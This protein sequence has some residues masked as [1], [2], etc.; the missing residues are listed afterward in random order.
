MKNNFLWLLFLILSPFSVS[1]QVLKQDTTFLTGRLKNGLTYYI[2][3]NDKEPGLA[4]FYIAK[5]VGS[6]LEE[7]RQRGL[8]H[9][10]EHMAFNGTTN[11][12]GDSKSPGIVSWCESVGVKFGANL[13]A[14]TSV[15]QTVYNIA[16]VPIKRQEVLDSALLILHD[17]CHGLLLTDKEIDKE[18]GVIH[19]EWRTRRAGKATQRMMERVLPMVYRGTK[20]EDCLPIGSMDIVDH[21][22]YHDLRDYYNKWY[23]PD[24]D[25]II[26]VGDIRPAEVEAKI[27]QLFGTIP[28]PEHAAERVYY[29][30]ADNDRIIVATDRDSEQPI[31]L[32]TLFMKHNA[33]SDGEKNTIGY[34]RNS[35]IESLIVSM[36]NSRL[37]ELQHQTVPPVLSATAHSGS[38]LVSKTKDAFWLSF[39][40]R[41]ENV[42]G[43][44][45]AVIAESE[46]ARRY[47]FMKSELQR[48]QERQMRMAESQYTERND[49][50]NRYFVN[51]A[52][53]NFLSNEPVVTEAYRREL[54]RNFS[55]TIS[56]EEVNKAVKSLI[57]DQNQVLVVYAPDKP[58]F[59]IPSNKVL[60]QYVLDAQA[61]AYKP[62]TEP[63]LSQKLLD[64]LPPSGRIV[65]EHTGLHG[66]K[67]LKLSNGVT[68]YVKQTRF[69]KDRVSMRF[70][71]EGGTSCYPD[72]DA[73][74]FPFIATAITDG[75][76]GKFDKSALRKMLASKIVHVAPSVSEDTQELSGKSSVRDLKTMLELTCLYFTEPRKDSIAFN[77]AMDRMYSFLTNREANPKV[78]Y[79]DS[80]VS[81]LYGNHLRMQPTRRETLK[82]VS[83][84]RVWQIY[85]ELFADASRFKML[86]VGNINIDSLRP[87]LCRYIASLPSGK[88]NTA[89]IT[90]TNS[91]KYP[92]PDVRNANELHLFKKKMNTPSALVNIFYTFEEPYTAKSDITLDVLQRVLQMAYTDSVREEKGGTYGVSV[93]YNLEKDKRPAAMLRITFRTDPAKYDAIIPVVYRQIKHIADYGPNPESM[94]KVKKY[95]LKN[96]G[97]NIIDN[98]YWDYVIYHQLQDG[99]DF[100]T[101]YKKMVENITGREVQQMAGNILNSHRRIEVT[102]L[103]E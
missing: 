55:E 67:V 16:S 87:L 62:Y 70:W 10:L 8:A 82:Q 46:R 37:Q 52:L 12:R 103:S 4:D 36:L 14:Y 63:Q 92:N 50:R 96:Y 57:S 74:N 3:H 64:R 47:G 25:A 27:K 68:V 86:L 34:L 95:L 85:K 45:D 78:S 54:I 31:M 23:R 7:P 56:L 76:V 98:G 39:G 28:Q 72:G 2:R 71:G 1:A 84:N 61:K 6:V 9:F 26:I 100:H 60:E 77:G 41:Q 49:Q 30:V 20:Y 48:A 88:N 19:E 15:D 91:R 32:A 90:T 5:R 58:E 93:S 94:E 24:L 33:V 29:P 59:E 44:F 97:Q 13:N 69:S 99:V 21:F 35:Y 101:G 11:F 83:Y 80:L 66:T 89:A 79:N 38:F 51:K 40:C 18:R 81:I 43:S 75:G 42:K 73:P 17:W 102:M 65:S 22:P 53:Q